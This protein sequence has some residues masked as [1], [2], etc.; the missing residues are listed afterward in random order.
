MSYIQY[1]YILV[2]NYNIYIILFSGEESRGVSEDACARIRRMLTYADV[3]A[4]SEDARG[5]LRWR[6]RRRRRRQLRS[7]RALPRCEA[8][9]KASC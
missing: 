6:R 3:C 9:L 5:H 1:M 7:W 8:R 4:C 2:M